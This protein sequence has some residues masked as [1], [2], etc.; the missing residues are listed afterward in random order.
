M[1]QKRRL[2]SVAAIVVISL[3]LF[4]LV[5]GEPASAQVNGQGEPVEL[6]DQSKPFALMLVQLFFYTILVIVLIAFFARF[7]AKRQQKWSEHHVFQHLG[8]TPLGTNKSVQLIKLGEKIYVLGVSD[9]ITLLEVIDDPQEVKRLEEVYETGKTWYA[10][11]FK[12]RW[13]T[14]YH[15]LKTGQRSDLRNDGVDFN[16]VLEQ[17]LKQQHEKRE[18]YTGLLP[19]ENHHHERGHEK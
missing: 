3:I 2:A 8:G 17:S 6:P 5:T 11:P 15:R 1:V 10:E 19:D 14:L 16:T 7:L 4:T 12:G 9:Q 18:H 13:A